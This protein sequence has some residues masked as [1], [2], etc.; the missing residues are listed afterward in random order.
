MRRRNPV[1][2]R[3]SAPFILCHFLPLFGL[4]T[5][6]ALVDLVLVVVLFEVRM[7]FIT[8]GY[9]RYFAHK[10]FQMNRAMQFVFAFGGLTAAQKG[11]LWWAAHHRTHHRYT[12]TD[13]DP[14]TPLRGFWWSHIGWILSGEYG[15]T[16]YEVIE[17]F[18]RYPELRFLN[19]H[20]WI[21]PWSLAVASFLIGGWSGL[22]V[23]FFGSTVLLW[24]ATFTVNS[25]AHV[26][27]RRRYET[28]DLSRNSLGVALL[29]GGEG[30]HNNHHHYPKS[31]RQGFYWWEIDVTYG[32]LRLL[33]WLGLVHDLRQPTAAAL[34]ARRVT[35]KV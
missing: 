15:A 22:F 6:F 35:M 31:A 10:S 2:W 13:R 23:G 21:G 9:H 20:D 5:G 18:A 24:H 17:D 19:R 1:S 30:W 28:D 11:P 7:F 14:H 3:T 26:F 33:A 27:G 12:D 25:F 34:D 16:N 8:A 29:T 4:F 32:V